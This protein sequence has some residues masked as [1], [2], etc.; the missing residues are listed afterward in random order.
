MPG[1][2]WGAAARGW[3]DGCGTREE[4]RSG[5]YNEKL[6]DNTDPTVLDFQFMRSNYKQL[7]NYVGS[8]EEALANED[9][10]RFLEILRLMRINVDCYGPAN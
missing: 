5:N 10:E 7:S 2:F 4:R 6:R 3:Y 8:L 9:K 1:S